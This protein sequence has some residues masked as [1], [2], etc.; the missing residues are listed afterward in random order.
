MSNWY[1]TRVPFG[2]AWGIASRPVHPVLRLFTFLAALI[3]IVVLA[4]VAVVVLVV[5][6]VLLPVRLL[7]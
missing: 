6:I 3:S 4:V 7:L 5:D 1:V 2:G